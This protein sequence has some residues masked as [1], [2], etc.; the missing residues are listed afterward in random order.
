MFAPT[1]L[2]LDRPALVNER[3]AET[4]TRWTTLPIAQLDQPALA[5]KYLG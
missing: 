4:K 1:E 2:A 5:G 3:A